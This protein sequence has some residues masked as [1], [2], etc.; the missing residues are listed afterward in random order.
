MRTPADKDIL[1]RQLR[2]ADHWLGRRLAENQDPGSRA[3]LEFARLAVQDALRRVNDSGDAATILVSLE[4][5]SIGDL[6]AQATRHIQGARV[7]C[8]TRQVSNP[9]V[10][11][12]GSA[13]ATA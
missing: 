13:R 9:S 10:V 1:R 11:T 8:R 5:V 4:R 7:Q 3:R 2:E 12:E 6:S